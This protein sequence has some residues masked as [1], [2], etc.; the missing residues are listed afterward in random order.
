MIITNEL[1][2]LQ[3]LVLININKANYTLQDLERSCE[4]IRCCNIKSLDTKQ[5]IAFEVLEEAITHL[6]FLRSGFV[7]KIK[8]M[9]GEQ[10]FKIAINLAPRYLTEKV[11]GKHVQEE[12]QKL[13]VDNR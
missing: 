2:N 9:D 13:S 4:K 3:K 11:S 10:L 5:K 7:E 1:S 8:H 12:I 6:S